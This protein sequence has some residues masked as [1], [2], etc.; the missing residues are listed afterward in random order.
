MLNRE[1]QSMVLLL[2]TATIWGFAFPYQKAAMDHIGPMLFMA[3]RFTVGT[4]SL[5]PLILLTRNSE[6][7]K[8][9]DKKILAIAGL[10]TG[11]CLFLGA[12]TQQVGLIYTTSGKSGF[13]TGLYIIIVPLILALNRHRIGRGVW[14]GALLAIM[15]LYLLSGS[16][17][18]SF[19]RGDALT[20]FSAVF[21]ALQIIILGWASPK[22]DG[23]RLATI[24]FAVCALLSWIAAI[25][26]EPFSWS[27]IEAAAVPILYTGLIAT[28]VAFTFQVI[29]QKHVQ[30]SPAAV[31]MSLEAVFAAIGGWLLLGETMS[32]IN[33]MGCALMLA[34]MLTAQLYKQ[35]SVIQI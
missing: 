34:G 15:G 9:S 14:M 11:V 22:T 26:F 12:G 13:I 24:Q 31:I 16:D 8:S 21:W 33:I 7:S 25:I 18:D 32:L 30:A 17:V 35:K 10:W 5:I 29:A 28:G 3:T 6:S 2:V 27:G 19:N 23:I 1:S 20:V 4:L